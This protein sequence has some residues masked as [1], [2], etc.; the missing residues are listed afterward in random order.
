MNLI[1]I[2]THLTM[3]DSDSLERK[4]ETGRNLREGEG[5]YS[6]QVEMLAIMVWIFNI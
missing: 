4:L 3:T 6:K 1:A 5:S 2:N